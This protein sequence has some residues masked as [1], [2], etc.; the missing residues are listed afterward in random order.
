MKSVIRMW[1]GAAAASALFTAAIGAQSSAI[2]RT[3]WGD[4]DIQGT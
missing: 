3:P 2:P 1:L 4:P